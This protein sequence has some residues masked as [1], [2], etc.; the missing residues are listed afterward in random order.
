MI[1]ELLMYLV[2]LEV[3]ELNFCGLS[4]NIKKN[5]KERA[6]SDISDLMIDGDHPDRDSFYNNEDEKDNEGE[7]IKLN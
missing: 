1:L 3:I 5:I 2:F 7:L 6:I 4:T